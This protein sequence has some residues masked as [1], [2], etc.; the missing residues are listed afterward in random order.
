ME[1][2]LTESETEIGGVEWVSENKLACI[3]R[4]FFL[5]KDLSNQKIDTLLKN[6]K[7]W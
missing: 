2:M 4:R 1:E 6:E 5:Q 3:I 7:T